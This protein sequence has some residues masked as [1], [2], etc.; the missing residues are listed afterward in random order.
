MLSSAKCDFFN[1]KIFD[2]GKDL[3]SMFEIIS[4][5]LQKKKIHQA[6]WK[7]GLQHVLL[8]YKVQTIRLTLASTASESVRGEHCV[9]HSS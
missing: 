3:K 4:A 2:C 5:I 8:L 7:I 1:R 9:T 6:N